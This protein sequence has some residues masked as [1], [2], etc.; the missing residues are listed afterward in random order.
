[1]AAAECECCRQ[2]KKENN[3]KGSGTN[4]TMAAGD[5]VIKYG[6]GPVFASYV[7]KVLRATV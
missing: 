4:H 1:M 2:T 6:P 3:S 5:G 7:Q